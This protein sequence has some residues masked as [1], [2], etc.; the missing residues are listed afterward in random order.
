M[1]DLKTALQEE[2]YKAL[3]DAY[4]HMKCGDDTEMANAIGYWRVVEA[5][6]DRLKNTNLS[7]IARDP[8]TL[9]R[10]SKVSLD[11][12]IKYEI[13]LPLAH[14]WI[15]RIDQSSKTVSLFGDAKLTD[16]FVD[17]ALSLNW[18]LSHDALIMYG[19]LP[20]I[21]TILRQ[22]RQRKFVFIVSKM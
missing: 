3:V 10:Y 5:F 2:S 4:K 22:K 9:D 1:N 14:G 21:A 15:S 12:S 7:L 8:R 11:T 20:L 13:L 16:A 6:I 19:Y 17:N 18:Y